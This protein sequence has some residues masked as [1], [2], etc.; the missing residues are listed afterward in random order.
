MSFLS[1]L[2][3]YEFYLHFYFRN[4]KLKEVG[5]CVSVCSCL[6]DILEGKCSLATSESNLPLVPGWYHG[7]GFWIT[8]ERSPPVRGLASYL[9]LPF[10]PSFWG[11]A[12][13]KLYN[14]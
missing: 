9:A 11:K 5:V 7:K 4:L 8:A 13:A 14:N 10:P 6:G 1:F 12:L 3:P 2:Y